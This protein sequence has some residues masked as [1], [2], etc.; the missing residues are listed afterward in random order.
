M[1][2]AEIR[3]KP[4]CRMTQSRLAG[5]RFGVSGFGFL[6]SFVIRHSSF[7]LLASL[8]ALAQSASTNDYS[9]VDAI[10]SAHCLD[11]HA[12]TD[13]EGQLVLESFDTL[14]KGGEIGPAVLP[15]KSQESLLVQM[16]EGRSE[17]HTSEL[18]SP[19]NLVCR[20]LLEKK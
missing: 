14:M 11:C 2:N 16:I 18:Q 15:G 1:T 6:S 3:K 7:L 5:R 4:E 20:L 19:C 8:P 13:P 10:F 9:A 12:S 17:E